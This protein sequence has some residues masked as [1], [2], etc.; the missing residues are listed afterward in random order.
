MTVFWIYLKMDFAA[1]PN[2]LILRCE[3]DGTPYFRLQVEMSSAFCGNQE[4]PGSRTFG[5]AA[6]QAPNLGMWNLRC[7]LEMKVK[8]AAGYRVQGRRNI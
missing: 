7:L 5:E 3:E 8:L 6:S 1:F 4:D 2:A